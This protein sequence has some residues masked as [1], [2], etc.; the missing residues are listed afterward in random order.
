MPEMP[1]IPPRQTRQPPTTDPLQ[2]TPTLPAEVLGSCER[3]P[4]Y[5]ALLI[6]LVMEIERS[7]IQRK[8][9]TAEPL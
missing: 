8:D 6:G 4:A 5:S 9:W 1:R 2:A 3:V 7:R